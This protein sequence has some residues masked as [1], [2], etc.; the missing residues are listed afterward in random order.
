MSNIEQSG[1]GG[2]TKRYGPL[3]VGG[4]SG[5][6]CGIS[7]ELKLVFE[8]SADEAAGA[9]AMAFSIP[10]SYGVIKD[11][12]VEVDEAFAAGT[13]DLYYSDNGGV[14]ATLLTAPIAMTAAGLVTGALVASQVIKADPDGDGVY[15]EVTVV[16]AGITGTAGYCKV[17][18]EFHRI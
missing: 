9:E 5:V 16:T 7:G 3:D 8:F 10:A 12:D 14:A 4:I 18:V 2:V 17:I 13:V 11:V 1:P 6:T 15:D